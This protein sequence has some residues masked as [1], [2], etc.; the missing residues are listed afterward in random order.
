MI[1]WLRQPANRVRAAWI[2]FW[3]SLIGW[4]ATHALIFLL[5]PPELSSWTGHLLLALSWGAISVTFLSIVVTTDVRQQVEE[6]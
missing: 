1:D 5:K 4:A 6:D 2:G 3:F